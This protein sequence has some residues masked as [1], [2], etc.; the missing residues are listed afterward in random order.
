M[1][2]RGRWIRVAAGLL[3]AAPL[4]AQ[5]ARLGEELDVAG[6]S[7]QYLALSRVLARTDGGF[8]VLWWQPSGGVF[9]RSFDAGGVP[10][11]AAARLDAGASSDLLGADLAPL[12][13]GGLLAVW[14]ERGEIAGTLACRVFA[15]RLDGAGAP[16]GEPFA[17][18]AEAPFQESPSLAV[19]PDG[20]LIVSWLRTGASGSQVLARR[21]A[22]PAGTPVGD[23][24]E[25]TSVADT[26]LVLEASSVAADRD[27]NLLFLWNRYGSSAWWALFGRVMSANG[28][29]G[30]E[31]RLSG[32]RSPYCASPA[33]AHPDGSGFLVA[34]EDSIVLDYSRT[35][36]LHF[37]RLAGDGSRVGADRVVTR[38][39][40]S[41]DQAVRCPE[42]AL[43]PSG[44]ILLGWTLEYESTPAYQVAAQATL[45]SADGAPVGAAFRLG[46]ESA[47]RQYTPRLAAIG[48]R[49]FVAVWGDGLATPDATI[50][51]RGQRFLLPPAGVDPC[52]FD[53]HGFLCDIA[54]GTDAAALAVPFGETGDVPLLAPIAGLGRDEL[55]VYRRGLFQCDL[56]RDGGEAELAFHFGGGFF[57]RPF[58]ADSNGDGRTDAC[59]VRRGRFLCDTAHDG[60]TAEVV[61]R[62]GLPTDTPLM[63]DVDGDG[64]DDPCL[65]RGGRFLCD[66]AHDGGSA[67]VRVRFGAPGEQPLL[68]D[69]D[70][71][72]DAD[73]CV[74][75]GAAFLCDSA[76][77]GGRAELEIPFDAAGGVP[78]LGNIDGL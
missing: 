18:G 13:G 32:D 7:A 4:A 50:H 21:L 12:Q 77:D 29:L 73:F 33:V 20:G 68:A 59:V 42:M 65:W 37:Q 72:G 39:D 30:A 53:G 2:A 23:E 34:W 55:C 45:L 22:P 64:D 9:A 38:L 6:P 69:A 24:I 10:L 57:D 70:A 62:F 63:G 75:R 25:V 28:G 74:Y 15:R 78:L 66:T 67:E 52:R 5:P 8:T 36:E 14:V 61:V 60:G 54:H 35:Q 44:H 58:L 41:G 31:F 48:E 46:Q 76:H 47:L 40:G 71:D 27:G 26:G 19:L 17:L 56:A 49:R 3:A 11:A 16:D 43:A 1:R 51:L